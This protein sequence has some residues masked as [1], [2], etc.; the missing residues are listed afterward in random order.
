MAT[1][2]PTALALKYKNRVFFISYSAESAHCQSTKKIESILI[3]FKPNCFTNNLWDSWDYYNPSMR[4]YIS[5][6]HFFATYFTLWACLQSLYVY[7]YCI[8]MYRAT[9][10]LSFFSLSCLIGRKSFFTSFLYYLSL[11]SKWKKKLIL[12][13]L[14]MYHNQINM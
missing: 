2:L 6:V 1:L 11:C 14:Q 3:V 5:S 9:F 4:N 7:K 13:R 10:F 12:K 8:K